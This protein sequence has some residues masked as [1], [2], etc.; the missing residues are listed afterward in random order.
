M[1]RVAV[2]LSAINEGLGLVLHNS[3]VANTSEVI[4]IARAWS[5]GSFAENSTVNVSIQDHNHPL[6]KNDTLDDWLAKNTCKK[7]HKGG[8][9]PDQRDPEIVIGVLTNKKNHEA[10]Q[11]Q[12]A[13]FHGHFAQMRKDGAVFSIRVVYFT[14]QVLA[15]QYYS[16]ENWWEYD[17]LSSFE[18][19]Q[20]RFLL[21][22]R[23]MSMDCGG[24][25][26]HLKWFMLIDDDTVVHPPRLLTLLATLQQ[27]INPVLH[28][29]ILGRD[30]KWTWGSQAS[31]FGG[32]GLLFTRGA[33]DTLAR[34]PQGKWMQTL[35]GTHDYKDPKLGMYYEYRMHALIDDLGKTEL[36]VVGFQSMFG[37]GFDLDVQDEVTSLKKFFDRG[38]H[39]VDWPKLHSEIASWKGIPEV[40]VTLHKVKTMDDYV[41]A[42]AVFNEFHPSMKDFI[43]HLFE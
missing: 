20:D 23:F 13:W 30:A 1:I 4:D 22:I 6:Q 39:H 33:L 8:E 5:H 7:F 35:Q 26:K 24:Y 27:K 34:A 42:D 37:V 18:T 41:I 12:L 2:L 16:A 9:D 10:A 40:V 25:N 3:A 36:R 15:D 32:N 21:A 38:K 43:A 11:A 28:S 14:N 29:N 17:P 31:L 19:A